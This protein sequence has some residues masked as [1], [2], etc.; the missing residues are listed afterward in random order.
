MQI[1]PLQ[2]YLDSLKKKHQTSDEKKTQEF[3]QMKALNGALIHFWNGKRESQVALE[4]NKVL[5]KAVTIQDSLNRELQQQNQEL[6]N[7]LQLAA[8]H[9][10]RLE[11]TNRLLQNM[12]PQKPIRDFN[13]NDRNHFP[14]WRIPL[15][16]C[17]DQGHSS[18]RCEPGRG[19][20]VHPCSESRWSHWRCC[21]HQ[22]PLRHHGLRFVLVHSV[23]CWLWTVSG[24]HDQHRA[25]CHHLL[26]Q[27]HH[28]H[29]R[30]SQCVWRCDRQI[31]HQYSFDLC[32][33]PRPDC[34][35]SRLV[36]GHTYL[37]D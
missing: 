4:E 28:L 29:Q 26:L 19:G 36:V 18:E 8:A 30:P 14:P 10:A 6:Q 5:K 24:R 37:Q 2:S 16:W 32:L 13:G 17:L 3:N 22:R 35:P 31:R 7:V 9:I 20:I 25:C 1:E 15:R 27:D 21:N 34:R 33:Q 23:V 11:D 12:P